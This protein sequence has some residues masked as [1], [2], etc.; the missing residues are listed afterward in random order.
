MTATNGNGVLW[1][2][3][4]LAV[5]SL[6]ALTGLARM[7]GVELPFGGGEAEGIAGATVKRGPLRI[8]VVERGNLK[9]KSDSVHA[10]AARSRVSTTVL[11]LIDGGHDRRRR[12][13]CV[14]ELDT[15]V[16]RRSS[17]V[18]QEIRRPECGTPRPTSRRSAEPRDPE[19][20]QNDQRHRER[21][22]GPRSS[23]RSG[24]RRSTSRATW[25]AGAPGASTKPS[26]IADEELTRKPSRTS[27]W[28]QKRLDRARLLLEQSELDADRTR[29]QTALGGRCSTRRQRARRSC[30]TR[31]TRSRSADQGVLQAAVQE[32][33]ARARAR[34]APGHRAPRRTSTPT[35]GRASKATLDARTERARED[36][37]R[38]S[39]S[40]PARVAGR[41][42]WSCTRDRGRGDAGAAANRCRK[43]PRSASA[44]KIITIPSSEGFIAELELARV[45]ARE[46]SRVGMDCLVTVGRAAG[47]GRSPAR[48]A[49]QEHV[50]P[51]SELA[52]SRTPT[53]ACT[54]PRSASCSQDDA[55]HQVR[56]CRAAVEILVDQ[57]RG[58]AVRARPG[59]VPRARARPCASSPTPGAVEK[60]DVVVGLRTTASGSRSRRACAE[61]EHRPAQRALR[62]S[63]CDPRSS[64][65]SGAARSSADGGEGG[66]D[67]GNGSGG[68]KSWRQRF[69]VLARAVEAVGTAS[70]PTRADVRRRKPRTVRA[71]AAAAVPSEPGPGRRA[72]T[73]TDLTAPPA[74]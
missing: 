50:L 52:G 71:T 44:K 37:R 70:V 14:C 34:E 51:G 19:V 68:S 30:W 35:C 69:H 61:G 22:A 67:H 60:R 2:V 40:R 56:A 53:C 74:A 49:L 54:A 23:P 39:R 72:V 57:H 11:W 4:G 65:R 7:A 48:V 9:A 43:A 38:R 33:D 31:T 18:Q 46:A 15:A 24:P 21:R 42:A 36:R 58:H 55:G 63:S 66:S 64:P 16:A 17:A 28:S 1:K 32:R 8:S 47:D 41:A 5:V 10:Q 62:A 13:S 59:R 25:P 20:S 6:L 73:A 12:A 29:G 3:G 45:G 26:C 27:S